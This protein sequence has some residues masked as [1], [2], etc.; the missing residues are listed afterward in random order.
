[1]MYHPDKS[2]GFGQPPPSHRT[3]QEGESY[4]GFAL[5]TPGESG[6]RQVSEHWC[7]TRDGNPECFAMYRRHY[8]SRK[9]RAPKQ[10]QFVGPG[11]SMVLIG[12]DGL[13]LFVWRKERF[14]QDGQTGV[15]CAVFRNE[16]GALSSTLII[17][18]VQLAVQKWP[19]ERLFT[20]V[21]AGQVRRKRDPGRCFTKAGWRRCGISKGGLLIFESDGLTTS[22]PLLRPTEVGGFRAGGLL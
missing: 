8:S 14:R 20:F 9:N 18:A 19:G 4:S 15:N 2:G 1:M 7:V 13:S 21:D 17:E 16:G 22:P 11:E 12:T 6:C 3:S 5:F 10:R